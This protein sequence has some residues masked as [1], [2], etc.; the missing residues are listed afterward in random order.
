[1]KIKQGLKKIFIQKWY[2]FCRRYG[3]SIDE[4]R[5]KQQ[6][7]SNRPSKYKE[8]NKFFYQEMKKDQSLPNENNRSNNTSENQE[9]HSQLA[10]IIADHNTLQLIFFAEEYQIDEIP[11]F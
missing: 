2:I 10:I 7:K 8:R 3:H 9:N 6:E 11:K 1:M 4:C 5:Q